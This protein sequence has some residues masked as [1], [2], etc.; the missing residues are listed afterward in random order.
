VLQWRNPDLDFRSVDALRRSLG[1]HPS[2]RGLTRAPTGG[3]PAPRPSRRRGAGSVRW[4]RR[5]R[6]AGGGRRGRRSFR[7]VDALRRSLGEHPSE[8]GLTRAPTGDDE[9]A[10]DRSTALRDVA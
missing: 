10:L 9:A 4:C 8:R 5:C 6:R 1:E 3:S 7:S 2:E